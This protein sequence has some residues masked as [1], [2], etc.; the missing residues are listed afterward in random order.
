MLKAWARRWSQ[1]IPLCHVPSLRKCWQIS[2]MLT[3]E[4]FTTAS[5]PSAEHSI[6]SRRTM[7]VIA[8]RRIIFICCE[9]AR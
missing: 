6:T 9:Y 2:S 1:S 8:G 4:A 5:V 7:F 3:R